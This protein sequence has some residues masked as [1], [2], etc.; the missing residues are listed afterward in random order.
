MKGNYALTAQVAITFDNS[1]G[2]DF[3]GRPY[4]WHS[5]STSLA[6]APLGISYQ[7]YV[8]GGP[9][10][11]PSAVSFV[12]EDGYFPLNTPYANWDLYCY[13]EPYAGWPN[14][15]RNTGDHYHQLSGD[16]IPYENETNLIPG[17]G[18]LC[19]IDKKTTLQAFGRLNN[20]AISRVMTKQGFRYGGYNLVGNP[21]QAYLDFDAFCADNDAVLEQAAYMLLDADKQ[22]Y[23][24]YCPGASDNPN[25]APR[26]LH[27]HQ[28]FFVQAKVDQSTL[29]FD[30][31][32]TVVTPLSSFREADG[33]GE[34]GNH[35]LLN[36]TVTDPEGRKDYATVEFG[37]ERD[38]GV[39]KMEGLH[40][41]DGVLSI[42]HKG[43]GYSIALLEG[44]LPSVPVR[45]SAMSDGVYTLHWEPLHGAFS[46]LHVIDHLMGTEVDGL[47]TDHYT[48]EAR[49]GDY[50]SR[51]VVVL[52]PTGVEEQPAEA[53]SGGFA[54]PAGSDW[55]I[56]GGG[57]LE[58]FDL[59]GRKLFSTQVEGPVTTLRL[60]SL[61]EGVYLLRL[62][63][64]GGVRTQRIVLR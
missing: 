1:D 15:K 55:K 47:R 28:G 13:D 60:P 58:L 64:P 6:D 8:E 10:G 32:Q 25:Y 24:T 38:G 17:K 29:A 48:F 49:T 52:D 16:P 44:R 30:P 56:L 39:L 59:L 33:P 42:G 2:S 27:P 40:A 34:T 43:Q 35:P 31:D 61:P 45:F 21:Y 46:Y 41:G 18:Y 14:F 57:G 20:G 11:A 7:D 26:Y 37:H 50:A 4:D 12:D 63:Q 22:G 5:F 54:A 62:V 23:V 19:A 53:V 3:C 51:F 36:L 9:S